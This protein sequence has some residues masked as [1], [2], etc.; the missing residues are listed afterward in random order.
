M[1]KDLSPLV[2]WL[3]QLAEPLAILTT[4]E[5][6]A[7][8][9]IGSTVY[10]PP[11]QPTTDEYTIEGPTTHSV[12]QADQTLTSQI[13]EQHQSCDE[14][15]LSTERPLTLTDITQTPENQDNGGQR[16][17]VSAS[18]SSLST[19]TCSSTPSS[20]TPPMV[21]ALSQRVPRSNPDSQSRCLEPLN[22]ASALNRECL[23]VE[24]SNSLRIDNLTLRLKTVETHLQRVQRQEN[25]APKASKHLPKELLVKF[26]D[27]VN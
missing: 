14:E 27:H 16:L 19:S 20:L 26:N 17:N 23:S 21:A 10:E 1:F 6:N 11:H 12:G 22:L 24:M 7:E 4:E 13:M 15:I 25:L 3:D 8:S 2:D 5:T 18:T 9:A